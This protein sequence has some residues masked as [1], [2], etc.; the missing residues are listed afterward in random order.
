MA[1]VIGFECAKAVSLVDA[2]T[3]LGV[4]TGSL[5]VDMAGV[6]QRKR[7]MVDIADETPH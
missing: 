3:G 4:V 6:A 1:R 7:N 2:S 5:R